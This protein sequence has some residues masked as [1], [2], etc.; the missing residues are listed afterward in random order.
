MSDQPPVPTANQVA[1]AL[2]D[3]LEP[4][5]VLKRCELR[6]GR[7]VRIS[8]AGAAEHEIAILPGPQRPSIPRTRPVLQDTADHARGHL[9]F[10]F[11]RE[12]DGVE[13]GDPVQ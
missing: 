9:R 8:L 4:I 6:R 2:S 11:A 13:S 3:T 10:A 7:A 12:K 5:N 1:A